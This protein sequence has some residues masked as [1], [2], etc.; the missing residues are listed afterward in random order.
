MVAAQKLSGP[1]KNAPLLQAYSILRNVAENK[2]SIDAPEAFSSDLYVLCGEIAFQIGLLDIC[3]ECLKMYFMKPQAANQFLCRAYLTQAQLLAPS[4]TIPEQLEKAVVYLLKAISF[5]KDNPRY[6]FLVYNASVIYWQFCRPFLKPTFRQF[7]VRSLHMVVRALDDIDDKDYEWRAQLMIALIECNLDD[8]KK[9]DAGQIATAA[10]AFIKQYVPNLYKQVFGLIVRNQLIDSSKLH[11]DIKSSPELGIYYQI[12]KMKVSLEK[13]EPKEYYAEIQRL[14]NQMGVAHSGADGKMKKGQ[15]SASTT[16]TDVERKQK[17]RESDR[18]SP[19]KSIGRRS[20]TPVSSKKLSPESQEKPHLLLELARLCLELNFPDLAEDCADHMKTCNVKEQGFYLELEFLQCDI[21]VKKLGT[22][23]ESLHK[24]IVDIRLQAMR[25]CEDILMN[26]IRLGDPNVIQVGCVTQWNLCLPLLQPNLRHHVR[27]P[28]THIAEALENIQSLLVQLRCRIH[29]ELAKCDEDEEQIQVA[30]TNLKKALAL[31]DAKIYQ[32]RLEVMLHRLE[33]RS[34][35]YKQPERPEDVAGMI[36]EQARKANSG[37]VRM[38]RSLLVKAGEALAP[39][40]FQFVMDSESETKDVSGGKAPL[41]QI[42]KMSNRARQFNKCVKKAIGHLQRLGN[43]NDRERAQLWGDLAKTAR[44]QEVW[45]VCRV[46]ARFCLL[47]DDQRW[48]I[49]EPEKQESPKS[50]EKM[51]TSDS[52]LV[53][54]SQSALER[55]SSQMIKTETSR[56]SSPSLSQ[57]SL[58]DRDLLR[59]FAEVN[60]IQ[61]EAVIHLLRSENVQLNDAPIPPVD[62]SKHPK[63]YVAKKPE[64][65]PD[66]IEYCDWIK[67]LSELSTKSFLRGLALGVEL[68]E[69]WL[70]CCAATYIWNYNNHVLTQLRHREI[71]DTL[72]TVFEGLKTVGHANETASLVN[73]CQAL[74][75]ALMKP[76]I[77]VANK[78]PTPPATP[79]SEVETPKKGKA[80]PKAQK[81]KTATNAVTI[82]PEAVTDLKKAIEVCEHVM[83]VTNG[84]NPQDVVPIVVRM[85]MLQMW[86]L[87]KQMAQQQITKNLGLDEEPYTEGQKAMSR[88]IVAVEML[89]LNKNG[90]MEFKEVPPI[91]EVATMVDECKWTDKF[92]ELQMWTQLTSLAYDQKLHALVVRCSK[93]ALKFA[94]AGTQSKNQKIDGHRQMVEQEMLS[95]S[96]GILGQSLVDNMGGKNAIRREALTAFLNSARFAAKADNYELVMTAARHYWNAC[97]SLVSQPI[98]RELLREPIRT[99]LQC[100]TETAEIQ[101][102]KEDTIDEVEHKEDEANVD[103][104]TEEVK[105]DKPAESVSSIDDDLTLRAALYG[106]LFQSYT[107]KGEWEAGLAAMDQAITDMPRTKHRLLLFKHRVMTKAKLGRSVT[108]DIQKFKDESEEYVAQMWRRVALM[109]KETTEQLLSY[110]NAIEALSSP[111][112]EWL[113]VDLLL[114]FAQFLYVKDFPL[115]DCT[116]QVEWA[117]DILHN[118][119]VEV[120]AKKEQDMKAAAEAA[121]AKKNSSK[122]KKDKKAVPPPKSKGEEKAPDKEKSKPTDKGDKK[123][124]ENTNDNAQEI[125]PVARLAVIGV[126]PANPSLKIQDHS[127]IRVLDGLICAHVLLA[128][129]VGRDAPQYSDYLLLAYTYLMRLWQVTVTVSGP[130]MKEILKNPPQ[131]SEN[132]NAKGSAKKKGD[133]GAEKA[134]AKEKPKRKGP[135]DV[136]PH[137]PEEWAVYDIPDEV[138]EAFKHDMMSETGINKNT[139]VKPML[140]LHYLESLIIKLRELGYNHLTLPI[141]AFEDLLSRDMLHNDSLNFLVHMRAMEVC[142]ELNLTNGCSFHEKI[143]GTFD[144]NELD[145]ARSRD[146]IALWKEKQAQVIKE[147]I[148]VRETIAKLAAEAKQTPRS[149]VSKQATTA[150]SQVDTQVES[151]LGKVI[152]AVQFRDVWTDTAEVLIRQGHY[153]SA[154]DFLTE[155]YSAAL[156]FEDIPLQARALYLLGTLAFEEAQYGQSVNFCKKAQSLNYGD[157]MFWYE[158]TMLIV[159]AT[160]NDHENKQTKTVARGIL[161]NALNEFIQLQDE[162]PNRASVIGY[163]LSMFEAKLASTQWAII[164]EETPDIN[165]PKVM[166]RVHEICERFYKA[167]GQ[168]IRLQYK[169]EALPLMKEHAEV[170]RKM[171]QGSLELEIRH[172]YYLQAM[173]VLKDAV[174]TAE[175]VLLDSQSL[176]LLHEIKNM[177]LPIQR[178]VADVKIA[179]GDLML[180]IFRV[181]AKEMRNKQLDDQRKGSVLK[182]VEDFICST[183]V[184]THMEKEWVEIVRVVNEDA[185]IKFLDAHNIA[186]NISHLKAKALC[187][188]GQCLRAQSLYQS[189]D[190][191]TQWFVSEME[192]AKLSSIA[193]EDDGEPKAELDKHSRH[194]LKYAKQIREMMTSDSISRHY[195]IQATEC[196]LQTLVLA[197]NKKYFDIA[198]I[199]ALELV[200]CF[201]QYDPAISSQ[202]LALFQ[203]CQIS[204]YLDHLLHLSQPDPS[205]SKLAALLHQRD[206]LLQKDLTYNNSSGNIMASIQMALESDWQAWKK[207]LIM[208]NHLDIYKDLP[209][210]FNFIILQHSPDKSFLYGAVLD[211]PKSSG[212]G[213]DKKNN[214]K[215]SAPATSRAKVIGTETNRTDLENLLARCRNHYHNVQQLLVKQEYQRSQAALRQKMLENLDNSMKNQKPKVLVDESEKE[216]RAL[217][218]EFRDLVLAMEAYLKPVT[219]QLEGI[220]VP[221][222]SSPSASTT[223]KHVRDAKEASPPAPEYAVILADPDLLKLPL[224]ALRVFQSDG[225][226]SLSRDFSLQLFFHRYFQDSAPVDPAGDDPAVAAKAKPKAKNADQP[227][228]RI[229]GL[230]DASK[231]MAKIIPLVRPGNPWN[232]PVDTMNFRFIVDPHLDCAETEVNKPIDVFNKVLQAYEQQF[233]PRWLGITG[234]DHVPSVGEWEI[235]LAENSSFV[236]YG[237]ERFLSYIPP[238]KLSALNIPECMIMYSLDL[239]QTNKSFTRQSKIDVIKS[240]EMLALEKPVQMAMLNSLAG[241]KCIMGNQ[242]H[243]TLA[244]NAAKLNVNMKDLLEAGMSTGECVRLLFTPYRR[245]IPQVEGAAEGEQA[246]ENKEEEKHDESATDRSHTS[247]KTFTTVSEFRENIDIQRSWYNLVCY[248]LP[249]LIVTQT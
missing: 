156:S 103:G 45:D 1:D 213:S 135:L 93:N 238:P 233:T 29:T 139:L 215:Q 66:W 134:P 18:R 44:K 207:K 36:I 22:K 176:Y 116:D 191:P 113:K 162:R 240:A 2:P 153:Q 143:A 48:K 147:E 68:Q 237:M 27:K 146:E 101:K 25:H 227:F 16:V 11:K 247:D 184:Y 52:S 89:K 87:A 7:L 43:E 229:P 149:L 117:I 188:I 41:T 177:S 246:G 12:C 91:T 203:S 206:N 154:K 194:F 193:E 214:P 164:Q 10:S 3:R 26:A 142:L 110:Q 74:A 76:W 231:K 150:F 67:S 21:T 190:A 140:T 127:D 84:N 187:G 157:E 166:K 171:A 49:A 182:M 180:E 5:A 224:E 245:K 71:M 192:L 105:K 90:I 79:S 201:G 33:L 218:D 178:E 72:N 223:E 228:S 35:L 163:I 56:P 236:F 81:N 221:Q 168:L 132:N 78:E 145:Q 144:I 60:F 80:D 155:A 198:A 114:E 226:V 75:Y 202:F 4:A 123:T 216:E 6:H 50:L 243:C 59:M 19:T 244:E 34:E 39:D 124:E 106:V 107:D 47:Y 183:P 174:S 232:I 9:T 99:I 186:G 222:V 210:N 199:A 85:P 220:L 32:E 20:P 129:I 175:A 83:M 208:V 63:G 121:E 242:W 130:T 241:V 38:K 62:K 128:D 179:C 160:L 211:K 170:L 86:A 138:I 200:E 100:I 37:T 217:Q 23:Q 54:G 189:P 104:M 13:N 219:S 94:T 137:T 92:V 173:M 119:Q 209:A 212:A 46:S 197:L 55:Q 165:I 136:I 205:Q 152:S 239:A 108:M 158:T 24:D 172:T 148:R 118:M 57:S 30:M 102:K 64:E 31:D 248:G 195:L 167:T 185:L 70:V 73:I 169:R 131:A 17:A 115:A 204:M 69:N 95:Y 111:S 230:R 28:L 249:N 125:I 77:P 159:N 42:K 196:L 8:G 151:H 51:K 181:H 98:E 161:V 122:G 40:A 15:S 14:L 58:Y 120:I 126:L 88:S 112:N 234:H 225:I 82:A 53:E 96:S 65:D 133:K 109:S 141:L 235:Y 97:C 61:G